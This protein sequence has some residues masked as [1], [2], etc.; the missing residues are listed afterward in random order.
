MFSPPVRSSSSAMFVSGPVGTSVT[1]AGW[2][3]SA[4]PGSRRRAASHRPPARR[5]QRRPVEAALAVDVRGDGELPYERPVGTGRHRHVGAADELEHADRVRR[6]L[7][8]RLVAVCRRHAE[9][10]QLRAG[11][12]QQERDRIVVPGIA[13]E[14]D[15]S[16][17]GA[18]IAADPA[19]EPD[20]RPAVRRVGVVDDPEAEVLV[21]R[22]VSR[23]AGL[24][25]RVDAVLARA[26]EADAGSAPPRSPALA[27]VRS[28]PTES[29]NQTGSSGTSTVDPGPERVVAAASVLGQRV[30][31]AP[32]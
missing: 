6:R 9:Q 27:R 32:R 3:R 7:L 19:H 8:E 2:R 10:L 14:D 13:V 17:H 1:G 30:H 16:R 28:T 21:D 18:S 4:P 5:R 15:R 29:R 23:R 22:H 20:M 31:P 11:E 12:R 25:E 24:E 26:F